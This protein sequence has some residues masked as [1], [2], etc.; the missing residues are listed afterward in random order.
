[1][2]CVVATGLQLIPGIVMY[3]KVNACHFL[4]I[5]TYITMSDKL[6]THFHH[7]IHLGRIIYHVHEVVDLLDY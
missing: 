4:H 1:M 2:R 3:F 7:N 5:K 6:N